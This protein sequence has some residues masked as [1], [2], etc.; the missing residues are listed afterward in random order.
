MILLAPDKT[1]YQAPTML[2]L[3]LQ[4]STPSGEPYK[5]L[6]GIPPDSYGLNPEDFYI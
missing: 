5:I 1:R 6:K 4:P 2:N 3:L